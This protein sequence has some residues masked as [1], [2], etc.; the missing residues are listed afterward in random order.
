MGSDTSRV[1]KPHLTGTEYYSIEIIKAMASLD[2][3]D[4][5]LL[6]AQKDPSKHLGELPPN[7]KT[8]V[9]P[10][11][12]LWSQFRLSWEMLFKKPDVLF[13]PSHL[14]PLIPDKI[15]AIGHGIDQDF[16][17]PDQNIK[18]KKTIFFIGRL[19]EKKNIIGMIRAY[20]TLRK[21]QAIKHQLILA[22]S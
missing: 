9:M 10:F 6:Y 5:F 15:P 2:E 12:R 14:V 1:T 3:T 4:D 19:E 21:E 13:V 7:F 22:G 11:P 20:E 18:K 17:R 8:K 16:F